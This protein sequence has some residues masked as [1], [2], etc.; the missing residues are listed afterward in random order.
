[1]ST[2]IHK[3]GASDWGA[4]GKRAEIQKRLRRIVDKHSMLGMQSQALDALL[5]CDLEQVLNSV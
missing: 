3:G 1:M 2:G 4:V 5:G